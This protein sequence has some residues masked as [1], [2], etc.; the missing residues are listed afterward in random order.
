MMMMML[1]LLS[2]AE[3]FLNST[4]S[5]SFRQGDEIEASVEGQRYPTA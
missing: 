5:F 1:L 2:L 4:F 3:H